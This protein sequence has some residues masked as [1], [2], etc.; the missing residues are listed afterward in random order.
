MNIAQH[1][2]NLRAF[3]AAIGALVSLCVVTAQAHAAT[4]T[5]TSTASSG[6]GTLSQAI[7]D[8]N[9]SDTITFAPNVSGTINLIGTTFFTKPLTI[10]GPGAQVL[11]VTSSGPN[12]I[13]SLGFGASNQTIRFSGLTLS[14]GFAF[15]GGNGAVFTIFGANNTLVL[16]DLILKNNSSAGSTNTSG[17]VYVTSGNSAIISATAIVSNTSPQPGV[18]VLN[19]GNLIMINSTL[20]NNRDNF[21]PANTNASSIRNSGAM[22][23]TNVTFFS[24]TT[25]IN[26]SA[27][28]TLTNVLLGNPGAGGNCAGTGFVSLGGNL[29]SDASCTAFTPPTD[30]NNTNPLVGPLQ[31]NGGSTPTHALLIGSPAVDAGVAAN[32]PTT[33]QR[34]VAR[35]Q[36][37]ACDIGAFEFVPLTQ[38]IVFG[39]LANRPITDPPFGITATASSGLTVTFASLTPATCS[40]SNT[41]VTLIA[42]GT[43]TLRALQGGDRFYQAA[44]NVDQSFAIQALTQTITF[45]PLPDRLITDPPFAVTAT[46]S[47][48]LTVTFSSLTPSVC[49][50]AS[51]IVTLVAAG[52]C[53]LRASQ[54]G[55]A[56][57]AP[58]SNVDRAFTVQKLSQTITFAAL[59]DRTIGDPSFTLTATA[60]SGLSVTFSSATP[61]ICSVTGG[62]VTLNAAGTCTVRASQAGDATYNAAPDVDRSFVINSMR[63]RLPLLRKD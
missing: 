13:F 11:T 22:T 10:Q 3:V 1:I 48:G 45:D 50:S 21:S 57:Y 14:G 42:V 27:P 28:A 55:D 31:N 15:V 16:S 39:P 40:I 53:T 38:T 36:G 8:A 58:A 26:S 47:S 61:A 62:M 54:A 43:C 18:A 24:N 9:P 17:A 5:V 52:Q 63:V 23:L 32:C 59:P 4:I 37:T 60:S 25:H 2:H 30:I 46:A 6:A 41:T 29:S 20:S 56:T 7:A 35:P 51:N 19:Q 44:P 33:D 49:T 12:G 34:S